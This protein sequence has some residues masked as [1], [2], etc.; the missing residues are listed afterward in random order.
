MYEKT[1]QVED[2]PIGSILHK[3]KRWRSDAQYYGMVADVLARGYAYLFTEEMPESNL[4]DLYNTDKVIYSQVYHLLTTSDKS[5]IFYCSIVS[6]VSKKPH[7]EDKFLVNSAI[8]ELVD[9]F[10][11]HSKYL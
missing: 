3:I 9:I 4:K 6:R 11:R 10:S 1:H 7:A 5:K 8:N 2:N